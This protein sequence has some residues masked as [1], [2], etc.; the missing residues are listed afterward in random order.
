MNMTEDNSHTP[1]SDRPDLP[2]WLVVVVVLFC[3][4]GGGVLTWWYFSGPPR[5][6]AVAIPAQPQTPPRRPNFNRAPMDLDWNSDIREF[7]NGGTYT[8]RSG[9]VQMWA[10]PDRRT[11]RMS[12]AFYYRPEPVP[13]EQLNLLRAPDLAARDEEAKRLKLT[14]D[15][16]TAL[17]KIGNSRAMHPSPDD[18]KKVEAAW[19][20][21]APAPAKATGKPK[22][23]F[24]ALVDELGKAY[25]APTKER[26]AKSIS[27]IRKVLTPE[28]QKMLEAGTG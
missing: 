1:S 16:V 22:A 28:Q 6:V 23:D 14:P 19:A 10:R 15:Q 9:T 2:T 4:I 18:I 21:L 11:K 25:L 26:L 3:L 5:E 20:A 12:F 24:L 17:K 8:I 7:R 27:D 13:R